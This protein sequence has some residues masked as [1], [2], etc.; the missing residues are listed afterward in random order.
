MRAAPGF[1]L[2][3]VLVAM[4][5]FASVASVVLTTSARSLNNAARLDAKT[6]ASWVADNHLAELQVRMQPLTRGS[7]SHA[8]EYAGR[9]WQLTREVQ[10]TVEPKLFRVTVWVAENDSQGASLAVQERA[11]V[12]LVGFVGGTR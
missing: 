12:T 8:L 9:R 4:A 1:T 10:P 7:Q 5:I 2:L 11:L 6:L 3:E